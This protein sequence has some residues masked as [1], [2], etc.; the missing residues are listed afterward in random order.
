MKTLFIPGLFLL[1]MSLASGLYNRYI[2]IP[3]VNAIEKK[4]DELSF[5]VHQEMQ[6]TQTLIGNVIIVTAVAGFILCIAPVVKTK[7][8]HS[9]IGI[10]CALGAIL[11]GLMPGAG[12]FF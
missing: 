10:L 3:K 7:I 8:S 9:V 1:L 12:I 5:L 6:N 2:Y 11:L 4:Y